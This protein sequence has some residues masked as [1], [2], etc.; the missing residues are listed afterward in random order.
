MVPIWDLSGMEYG[1]VIVPVTVYTCVISWQ[2]NES[3][4][5]EMGRDLGEALYN[6]S[7]CIHSKT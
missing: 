1:K 3:D 2:F 6:F 5:C 7:K 4:L